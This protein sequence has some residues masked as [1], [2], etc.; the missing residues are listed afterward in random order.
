MGGKNEK[1]RCRGKELGSGWAGENE[2]LEEIE[3]KGVSTEAENKLT[4]IF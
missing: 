1:Q 2:R 4:E 3:K